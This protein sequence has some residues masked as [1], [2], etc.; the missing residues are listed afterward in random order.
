MHKSALPQLRARAR[1]RVGWSLNRIAEVMHVTHR[2]V[3][4]WKKEDLEEGVDWEARRRE[5]AKAGPDQCL[6]HLR[7]ARL[8]LAYDQEKPI[9]ERVDGI[10]ELTDCIHSMRM[11][12]E[13]YSPAVRAFHQLRRFMKANGASEEDLKLMHEYAGRYLLNKHG[14]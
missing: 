12:L 2:T 10:E 3:Q 13:G 1:F 8:R 14:E 11:E 7:E 5:Y 9:I 6:Q 4:R